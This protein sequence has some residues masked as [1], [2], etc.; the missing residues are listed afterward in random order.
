MVKYFP[1]KSVAF[2]DLPKRV[3]KRL[4]QHF[5]RTFSKSDMVRP[6]QA[7][8]PMGFK[9]AVY[10][11]H[12]FAQSL[13]QKAVCAFVKHSTHAAH[14]SSTIH[15]L[16]NAASHIQ[17]KETDILILHIIDD[18][19]VVLA[20]WQ[21]SEVVQFHRTCE[22]VFEKANFPI[23]RAKSLPLGHVEERS[24]ELIGWEWDFG[25]AEI[26]PKVK[27]I[28]QVLQQASAVLQPG[29]L[30]LSEVESLTGRFVWIF[31][32]Q[33]PLL[34]ILNNIFHLTVQSEKPRA[35]R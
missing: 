11:A 1:L 24:I 14:S 7:T 9:W 22:A 21:G 17:L 3:Q 6:L 34:S 16:K 15:R 12:R 33:R 20:E 26:R 27:Q 25:V 8:L 4:F 18:I 28:E 10:I 31:L 13:V 23:N 19:S 32:G 2:G 5:K 29:A 30:P 35:R